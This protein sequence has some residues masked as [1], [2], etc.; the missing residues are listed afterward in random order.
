MG[1]LTLTSLHRLGLAL[2]QIKPVQGGHR[3][4]LFAGR[5]AVLAMVVALGYGDLGSDS[6]RRRFR[7]RTVWGLD[8]AARRTG[9]PR[10]LAPVRILTAPLRTTSIESWATAVLVMLAAIG[11]HLV[12]VLSL[13]P[14]F[15]EEA[16][17]ATEERAALIAA[18]RTG[19]RCS[20]RTQVN[21]NRLGWLRCAR[22][23]RDRWHWRGRT[24]WPVSGAR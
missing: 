14:P 13:T 20:R 18:V 10:A 6:G 5:L 4:A 3:L 7:P 24:R 21:R 17:L 9:I 16:A 1:F 11:A 8:G 19:R 15:E 23:V 22:T 12:W 2:L